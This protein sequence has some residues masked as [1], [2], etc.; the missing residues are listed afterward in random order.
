MTQ[1]KAK[2]DTTPSVPILYELLDHGVENHQYFQGCGVSCTPWNAVATGC[3]EDFGEALDDCLEQIAQSDN[4]P[5]VEELEAQIKADEGYTDKPWP[6]KP[7]A[8][9]V[10]EQY[11]PPS[12]SEDSDDED[13]LVD[14]NS[15]EGNTELYYY[16][17]IRY[18][19]DSEVS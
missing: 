2:T 19:H 3:G 7:S 9:S 11:N 13:S 12:Q 6:S 5:D 16:V 18:R 14:E 10:Y 8:T 4:P 15:D 1:D 17:S